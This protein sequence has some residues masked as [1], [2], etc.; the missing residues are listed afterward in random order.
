MRV[1]FQHEQHRRARETEEVAQELQYGDV[2]LRR[3]ALR[4]GLAAVAVRRRLQPP[5]ITR[6]A[7]LLGTTPHRNE[8]WT[9]TLNG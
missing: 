3:A 2:P 4:Y 8:D 6:P 7:A 5:L 1:I 9:R